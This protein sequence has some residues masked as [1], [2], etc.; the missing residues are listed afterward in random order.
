MT[1]ETSIS[2]TPKSCICIYIYYL[3]LFAELHHEILPILSPLYPYII[4]Y[5]HYIK[6]NIYL[7]RAASHQNLSALTVRGGKICSWALLFPDPANSSRLAG[8]IPVASEKICW[9]KSHGPV[10]Q[11]WTNWCPKKTMTHSFSARLTCC[12]LFGL[13]DITIDITIDEDDYNRI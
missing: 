11:T 7:N 13:E 3:H 6:L 2:E 10:Q 12:F 8:K 9:I 1:W 4:F 5:P